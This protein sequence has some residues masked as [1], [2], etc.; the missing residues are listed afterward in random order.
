[1]RLTKKRLAALLVFVMILQLFATIPVSAE[2]PNA[3]KYDVIFMSDL[4]NAVGGYLGFKQMLSE[5]KNEGQ[6]PRVISHGG[7]YV[8]DSM[9]GQPN[10]QTQVYDVI[11]GEELAAF[12]DAAQAYTLG[13]HDWLQQQPRQGRRVQV[14]VR[15]RPLR[16]GLLR[17]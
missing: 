8:E 17:R 7:D 12:P 4:H 11:H 10:W 13:N 14:R 2:I 16:P 6:N 1:M 3:G 9:G 5:L 15:L